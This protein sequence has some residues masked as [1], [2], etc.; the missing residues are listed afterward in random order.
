[1]CDFLGRFIPGFIRKCTLLIVH[2]HSGSDSEDEWFDL[3]SPMPIRSPTLPFPAPSSPP[4]SHGVERGMINPSPTKVGRRHWMRSIRALLSMPVYRN[5]LGGEFDQYYPTLFWLNTVAVT[6]YVS[7]AMS[8]LYFTV[9]GVQYWGT[10]YLLI[11]LKAPLLLVNMLFISCAAT[12]PVLGVIFG[13]YLIDIFGG[14]KGYKRRVVALEIVCVLGSFALIC[15]LPI[16]FC[17]NIY[18]VIILLWL[19]LFFGGSILPACAGILVSIV[20]RYHRPTSTSLSLVV[21]NMFGYCLSL[22]LSGY[23]MQVSRGH[24]YVVR[25][26]YSSLFMCLYRFWNTI[27]HVAMRSVR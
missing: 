13:G 2:S 24:H 8:A 10:K 9:T 27:V 15:S 12:G 17:D 14:Y 4:S 19:V 3:T 6:I 22:V 16:T 25:V 23:L 21:F 7:L 1:M 20:P 26:W 11:S 18:N 5:L